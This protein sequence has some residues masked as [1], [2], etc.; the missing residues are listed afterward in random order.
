MQDYDGDE[1]EATLKMAINL[2]VAVTDFDWFQLLRQHP[3]LGRY[4]KKKPMFAELVSPHMKREHL[5]G[6]LDL[7][8]KLSLLCA[9]IRR[10]NGM[11]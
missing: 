7:E 3:G 8:A 9:T 10:W 6:M 4:K 11:R 2:V 1:D 5:T